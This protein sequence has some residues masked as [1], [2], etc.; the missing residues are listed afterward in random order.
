MANLYKAVAAHS[1]IIRLKA[2]SVEVKP[3]YSQE[4]LGNFLTALI[5]LGKDFQSHNFHVPEIHLKSIA[6]KN[7]KPGWNIPSAVMQ[8]FIERANPTFTMTVGW[9]RNPDT[10]KKFPSPKL[11]ISAVPYGKSKPETVEPKSTTQE[12]EI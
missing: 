12:I 8:G 11:I 1:D 7:A 6:G 9:A 10:G 4:A 2:V 5:A 3:N